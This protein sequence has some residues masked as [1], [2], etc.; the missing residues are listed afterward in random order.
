[1]TL[2]DILKELERIKKEEE[3]KWI[4][5]YPKERKVKENESF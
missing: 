3:N 1:M 4:K 2:K 5:I